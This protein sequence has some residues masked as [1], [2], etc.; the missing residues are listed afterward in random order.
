M[1]VI[2][3]IS[4]TP[5]FPDAPV[6]DTTSRYQYGLVHRFNGPGVADHL[7]EM[8]DQ[9]LNHYPHA[10]TVGEAPGIQNAEQALPL[11]KDGKP[12]QVWH[13]LYRSMLLVLT[14]TLIDALP[15]RT[16]VH[17]PSAR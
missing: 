17:R 16:H 1:D 15:F 7:H 5:G 9:V 14:R 13:F 10:F 3:C 2:N 6:T 11:V 12:L 4:K 8:H